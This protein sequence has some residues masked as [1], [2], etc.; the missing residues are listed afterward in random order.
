MTRLETR[1]HRHLRPAFDLEHAD[2]VGLAQH[3]VD[4]GIG[5][6][7]A[8]IV[9]EGDDH[10]LVDLGST[11]GIET[12]EGKVQRLKLEDGTRF[13]LG[14]TEIVVSRELSAT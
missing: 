4:L 10:W 12:A 14:S 11:N 2:R 9:Q 8:E 6:R 7:H 13:V 3:L 1:Q 5:R